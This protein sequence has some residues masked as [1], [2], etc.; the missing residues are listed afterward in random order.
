MLAREKN[1]RAIG[2]A[3]LH[4]STCAHLM[5]RF[6]FLLR[7][8]YSNFGCSTVLIPQAIIVFMAG[9]RVDAISRVDDL[10]STV[11]FK[12]ICSTVQASA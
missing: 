2:R 4:S 5:L 1:K 10:I 11:P 12:S 3:T 8:V 9:E 7:C 6:S